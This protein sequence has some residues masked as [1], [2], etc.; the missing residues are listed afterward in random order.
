[1]KKIIAIILAFLIVSVFASC[2]KT[3]GEENPTE[4]LTEQPST[5]ADYS[6][7]IKI[8]VFDFKQGDYA[9]GSKQSLLG[10]K[11]ANSIIPEIEIAEE[12][13]TIKLEIVP[14]VSDVQSVR[15]AAQNLAE[16]G[17]SAVIWAF[18]ND[19]LE[20]VCDVFEKL[21]IP[22]LCPFGCS[23]QVQ[24]KFSN[25]FSFC[26]DD[27]EQAQKC[28]DYA[29]NI[30]MA[31]KVL[32][33]SKLGDNTSQSQAFYFKEAFEALGGSAVV[34]VFEEDI[35]V[36]K[37]V[38]DCN[39]IYAPVSQYYGSKI[40]AQ[41]EASSLNVSLLGNSFWDSALT[42]EKAGKRS[43][44]VYTYSYCRADTESE[45]YKSFSSWI[46]DDKDLEY[47]NGGNNSVSISSYYSHDAYMVIVNSIVQA[48]SFEAKNVLEAMKQMD[49]NGETGF[50][51]FD[52]NGK[53]KI[54]TSCLKKADNYY[55]MWKTV[56]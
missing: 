55:N 5:Q 16:S 44:P 3:T 13:Y 19:M 24:E 28:A 53:N 18:E 7:T 12:E 15:T 37:N 47:L 27:Y 31:R 50:I 23:I 4:S 30:I 54:S 39:M 34:K 1:M 43:F 22:V 35:E 52:E 32:V 14:C 49:F 25:V 9:A 56:N 20:K 46:A 10:I 42:L 38:S 40:I 6:E 45:F 26:A 41:C 51:S 8:G 33:L 48:D 21:N 17:V 29:Y 36:E 2:T 11:Y